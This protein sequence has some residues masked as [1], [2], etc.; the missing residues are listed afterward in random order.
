LLATS[1]NCKKCVCVGELCAC[2]CVV[3]AAAVVAVAAVT[4]T[5]LRGAAGS[6]HFTNKSN[7]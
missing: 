7:K 4:L 5:E 2:P 6:F 3:A 1:C